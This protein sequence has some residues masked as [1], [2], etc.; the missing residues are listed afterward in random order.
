MAEVT[1]SKILFVAGAR[2]NFP[3]V[4]PILRALDGA[5][6]I[7]PILVHTGQ[8]YDVELSDVFFQDL[9]LPAPDRLLGVGSGSHGEQTA[10]VLA[11]FE[12]VCE[13]ERPAAVVVVGDVNSTLA[14]ALAAVKLWIPVAHVEAGLR[15]RDR[16]M[17]E[18]INRLLTVQVSTLL[19]TH[20][21]EADENLAAE[22]IEA[23]RI[24][25]V[26]NTMID[27]LLRH[28]ARARPPSFVAEFPLPHRAFG[29]VTLHRPALVDDPGRLAAMF[30]ALTTLARELPL[31]YPVHPRTRLCLGRMGRLDP[32]A[33][34][35]LPQRVDGGSLLLV[36][37][38]RYLEFV[39]LMDHSRLVLTDSGG[40]QEETTCLGVPCL[41]VRENTERAITE[42]E[43]TNRLVG[44]AP[45]A[46]LAAAREELTRPWRAAPGRPEL[47]DGK[48]GER[49]AADLV[50]L[51]R[52]R[53][54]PFFGPAAS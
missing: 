49:I 19:F 27:T 37:P 22:G 33:D 1:L 23:R 28:L 15:S 21:R 12:Q 24:R 51:V 32:D 46:M 8:H 40:V 16:T 26:G 30:D 45:E 13:E 18:E 39:H 20:C 10:Q 36:S 42:R 54:G 52:G 9:D 47:W 7:R 31:V 44:L 3:K 53:T 35:S 43:G 14:C 34:P 6:G 17:P 48:A 25:F 4:A 5:E 41:T 29:L 50:E 38:V 11:A 2:P